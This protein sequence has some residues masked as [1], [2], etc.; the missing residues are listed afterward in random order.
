MRANNMNKITFLLLGFILF[1][2]VAMQAGEPLSNATISVKSPSGQTF[3]AT[4][5]ASG[6]C[7]FDDFDSESGSFSVEVKHKQKMWLTSNFRLTLRESPTL[8]SSGTTTYN[9]GGK[10]ST[11]AREAG[12][13][14]STGKRQYEPF[15]FKTTLC[16]KGSEDCDDTM[17]RCV[18]TIS[19]DGGPVIQ[20]MAINEKG[21]PGDKPRKPNPKN[22]P[23]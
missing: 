9:K 3:T 23:K 21:L 4:T 2:Y 14:M 11:A 8:P 16:P 5:D 15:T 1:S 13:G 18:V 17:D 20:G 12:S 19:C 10:G 6:R 22:N 7:V